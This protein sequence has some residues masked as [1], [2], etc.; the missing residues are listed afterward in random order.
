MDIFVSHLFVAD[1]LRSSREDLFHHLAIHIRK[2]EV[3]T[4]VA[5]RELEVINAEEMKHGGVE[6][7]DVD[8]AVDGSVAHVVSVAVGETCFDATTGDP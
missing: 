5:R 4:E 8:L 6:I 3:A 7:V 2:A 1:G